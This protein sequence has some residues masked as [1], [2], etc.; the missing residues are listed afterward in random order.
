MGGLY[1]LAMIFLANRLGAAIF[2]GI[3]VTTAIITSTA[4]D[5]FGLLGFARHEA[6]LWRVAGCCLMIAGLGLVS[7][8]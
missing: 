6:S 3:T 5:H 1:I 7:L 2:T 4:L 8:F